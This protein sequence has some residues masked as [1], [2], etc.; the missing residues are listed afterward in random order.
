MRLLNNYRTGFLFSTQVWYKPETLEADCVLSIDLD[1]KDSF[2]SFYS[3]H[4]E[5]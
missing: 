5:K 4:L 1:D 2:G 3:G